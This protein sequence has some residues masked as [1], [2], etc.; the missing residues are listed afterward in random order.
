MIMKPQVNKHTIR[1]AALLAMAFVLLLPTMV[2]GQTKLYKEYEYRTDITA[3][4]ILNYPIYDSVKV[5]ITMLVPNEKED[6]ARLAEDFNLGLD[7]DTIFRYYGSEMN[8]I[9]KRLVYKNNTKK[10]FRAINN[11]DDYKEVSILLYKYNVGV[12]VIFHNIDTKERNRKVNRFFIEAVSNPEIL[13]N[14]DNEIN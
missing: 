1:F 3:M 13:P 2:C 4:C 6:A 12:I 11:P 10:M 14:I 8:G 7:K 9:Y 5:D